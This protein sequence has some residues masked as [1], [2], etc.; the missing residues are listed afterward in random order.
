MSNSK[1]LIY[2][3][4]PERKQELLRVKSQRPFNA[5]PHTNNLCKD[6]ITPTEIFFKRN[7]GPI[8][9]ISTEE[10]KL[11]ITSNNNKQITLNY[12]D[13]LSYKPSTILATLQVINLYF[14]F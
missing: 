1:T 7:H 14:D 4:E 11:N 13:I 9:F 8:P 2:D 5:E 12:N 10:Y 6:Y 3:N